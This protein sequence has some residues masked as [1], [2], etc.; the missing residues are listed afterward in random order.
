MALQVKAAKRKFILA[1]EKG[2]KDTIELK[3][4]HPS[5]SVQEVINHYSSEHP[6]LITASVEGP[7][8]EGETA[9]YTFTS[10]LG[11]KG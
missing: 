2:K 11:T 3:D 7:K 10:V 1:K 6:E 5:M 9:A 8:M 4:P